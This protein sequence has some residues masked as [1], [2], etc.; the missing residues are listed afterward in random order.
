MRGTLLKAII[1][2]GVLFGSSFGVFAA[3]KTYVIGFAQ[4]NMANDWRAAQVH[5]VQKALAKYDNVRFIY[6]D[7][8]GSVAQNIQDI[9]DLGDR[10]IDLLIMSPRS[11]QAMTPVIS[12]LYDRGIPVV[13]LTR[14]MTND[15]FTTFIG[16][17][18]TAIASQAADQIAAARDGK[19]DVLV[20]QGVPTAST[21]IARTAGFVNRIKNHR[22][23][24]IIDIIPANYQRAEAIKAVQQVIENG[25]KFDAIY[26]QSDSMAAGARLALK[27]SGLDPK[28][29]PIVGIDYIRE[30]REAIQSGEQFA[31]FTYPTCGDVGADVA[32]RILRGEQVPRHIEVPSQMVT[33]EN[34]DQIETIF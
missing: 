21:A 27:E 9:E 20:L 22:G 17:N 7:A 23:L 11:P 8:G 25:T 12:A 28:T 3:E 2:V 31:S 34:V 15:K 5:A 32:M 19:G 13:L 26:A 1:A 29:I 14:T 33:G 30:A 18:D 4:D 6:T 24:N 16:P 10:G